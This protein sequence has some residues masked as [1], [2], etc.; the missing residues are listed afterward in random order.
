MVDGWEEGWPTGS[1]LSAATYVPLFA[2]ATLCRRDLPEITNKAK[3]NSLFSNAGGWSSLIAAPVLDPR[4][5][6]ANSLET[7]VCFAENLGYSDVNSK[8]SDLN[9]YKR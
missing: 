1:R 2:A 3:S 9:P 8:T 7:K 5:E 6:L 4:L